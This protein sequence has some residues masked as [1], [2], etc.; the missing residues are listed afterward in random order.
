[1]LDKSA[2]AGLFKERVERTASKKD[3][4]FR[5][6]AFSLYKKC[7]HFIAYP[8][9]LGNNFKGLQFSEPSIL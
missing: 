8:E 2:L 3:E 5:P 9:K 1:M 6:N 4:V 7:R